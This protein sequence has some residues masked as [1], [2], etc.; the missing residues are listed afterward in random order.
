MI[1]QTTVTG[2]DRAVCGPAPR[3]VIFTTIAGTM[4]ISRGMLWRWFT[5]LADLAER[6]GIEGGQAWGWALLVA[7]AAVSVSA[8][9]AHTVVAAYIVLRSGRATAIWAVTPLVFL[10]ITHPTIELTSHTRPEPRVERSSDASAASRAVAVNGMSRRQC[11]ETA[12]QRRQAGWSYKQIARHLGVYPCTVGRWFADQPLD[13]ASSPGRAPS[14]VPPAATALSS[15]P[16]T[17]QGAE[18]ER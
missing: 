3:W 8:D 1:V 7:S 5:A 15:I 13:V 11:R 14:E 2:R 17:T 16:S 6:A 4:L 9:A 12:W 10:A 18:H